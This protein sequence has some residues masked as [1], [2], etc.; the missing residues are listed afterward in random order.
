M[1][2]TF[3]DHEVWTIEDGAPLGVR[4]DITVPSATNP[5]R[6]YRIIRQEPSLGMEGY[7]VHTPACRGW[8]AGKR[9][10]AHVQR[11]LETAEEPLRRL[12]I[13]IREAWSLVGMSPDDRIREF[14]GAMVQSAEQALAQADDLDRYEERLEEQARL[15]RR[16][17]AEIDAEA[18]QAIVEFGGL[19][20]IAGGRR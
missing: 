12:A 3:R 8:R 10:C 17:Q 9:M 14:A 19:R 20:S 6:P 1:T 11:A 7:L 16:S 2:V 13:D 18:E 15:A 5:D 4:F